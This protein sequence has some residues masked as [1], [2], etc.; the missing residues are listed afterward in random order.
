MEIQVLRHC[1]NR[2]VEF[3][4]PLHKCERLFFAGILADNAS[5][6]PN[7]RKNIVL[8]FLK[9]AAKA[10]NTVLNMSLGPHQLLP[11]IYEMENDFIYSLD[12]RPDFHVSLTDDICY[13]R[14][15]YHIQKINMKHKQTHY[16]IIDLSGKC[17]IYEC[18]NKKKS[19]FIVCIN[20][21]LNR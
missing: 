1:W 4:I 5:Q 19:F 6:S 10:S 13:I 12:C 18:K 2:I 7:F 21:M 15:K 17:G 20:F 14:T 9:N 11:Q 16:T 8:S 3:V